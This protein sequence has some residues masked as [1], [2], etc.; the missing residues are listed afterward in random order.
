MVSSTVI[1]LSYDAGP[2][3]TQ[4]ATMALGASGLPTPSTSSGGRS[5]LESKGTNAFLNITHGLF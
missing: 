1:P 3:I 4:A 5:V 2:F